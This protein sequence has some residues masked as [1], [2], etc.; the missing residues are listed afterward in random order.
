MPPKNVNLTEEQKR[1]LEMAIE[2]YIRLGL[3]QFSEIFTRLD[4]LQGNRLDP[5]KKERL[6]QLC[7]E[8]QELTQDWKLTDE[9]T[10]LYTLTAFLIEAQMN[11]NEK[12]VRWAEKRIRKLKEEK[13]E[14][15]Q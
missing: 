1:V 2:F 11:N 3:G 4:L 6:R 15:I 12:S 7:E 13:K 5:D 14:K 9:E 10:S 8:M